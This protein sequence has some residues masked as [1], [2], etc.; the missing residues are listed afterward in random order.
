MAGVLHHSFR[1]E[2]NVLDVTDAAHRSGASRGPVHAAGVKFHHSFFV[3][4]AAESDGIVVGIVFGSLYNAQSSV[5]RVAAAFQES[6]SVVKVI[7]AVV[8]ADD[9]R[10]LGGA[11]GI[12][13]SWIRGSVRAAR[14]FILRVEALRIQTG[15]QRCSNCRT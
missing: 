9:D 6:E 8:G 7:D 4:K 15:G 3:G 5:E 14:R 1:N 12:V 13:G 11:K 2:R 10:A